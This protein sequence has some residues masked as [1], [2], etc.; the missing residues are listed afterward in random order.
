MKMNED[1]N[2]NST[3]HIFRNLKVYNIDAKD[4]HIKKID[5]K[6]SDGVLE[7]NLVDRLNEV[8]L[9]LY[10]LAADSISDSGDS[11][12]SIYMNKRMNDVEFKSYGSSRKIEL[13]PK[14]TKFYSGIEFLTNDEFEEFNN[15]I[16][17]LKEVYAPSKQD[18]SNGKLPN[19]NGYDDYEMFFD[20][21]DCK[22]KLNF[23]MFWNFILYL[24][25]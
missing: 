10:S 17:Y 7:V 19:G 6:S 13:K 4:S 23:I 14:D 16:A 21:D 8:H 25:L 1:S 2:N 20:V 12:K 11:M 9:M 15:T 24:F 5:V 3:L 18:E 22:L